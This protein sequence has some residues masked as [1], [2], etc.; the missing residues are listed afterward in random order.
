MKTTMILGTLASMGLLSAA[1]AASLFGVTTDNKLVSFDTAAPGSFTSSVTI[2]G[3]FDADGVTPNPGGSI[4]NLAYNPT[5]A[6]LYG[7]DNNANFY[8]INL[9]GAATLVSSGF[10]PAGFSAGFAYDPFN[11][12][13]VFADDAAG[14]H[15]ITTA[16]AATT[17]ANF[18]YAGG[19][20][21]SIFGLA[22]DQ[23]FGTVFAIDAVNDSL[24]TS[25]NP[26]FPTNSELSLVGGLG[27]DVTA[28]GGLVVDEDGNVFAALST[29]GLTSGLYSIDPLTGAATSLGSFGGAGLASIAVPEPSA[30]L[31]GGLGLLAIFRR[32][33]A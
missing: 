21:P 32:R 28:F 16:G 2:T 5:D 3:L 1:S 7:I 24:S 12:N 17:N 33:R 22:I 13:F 26:L 30:A 19:G 4:L 23:S 10:S 14:N 8:Q 29:D 25:I 31:L 18:T 20:T 27:I 15:S 11:N 9:G 6:R